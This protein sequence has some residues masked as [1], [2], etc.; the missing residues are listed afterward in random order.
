MKALHRFPQYLQTNFGIHH[1]KFH[2]IFQS[3][4]H[5][6]PTETQSFMQH[7]AAAILGFSPL[8]W[9]FNILNLI[10]LSS[11][12]LLAAGYDE[13]RQDTLE[14]AVM[15]REML[16][17]TYVRYGRRHRAELRSACQ[18]ARRTIFPK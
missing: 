13:V 17:L 11:A 6:R 18:R 10:L 2:P 7:A 3:T 4:E 15:Q 1:A 12:N 14:T 5:L 8:Q 16:T 9:Q